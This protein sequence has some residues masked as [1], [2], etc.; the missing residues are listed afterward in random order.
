MRL[1]SFGA[2]SDK[3]YSLCVFFEEGLDFEVEKNLFDFLRSRSTPAL[4]F[5]YCDRGPLMT[6]EL[7]FEVRDSTLKR[8]IFTRS[9]PS[10][11]AKADRE[12]IERYLRSEGIEPQVSISP[13]TR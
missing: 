4:P 12:E 1:T 9:P 2:A 7:T 3:R 5:L 8:I 6:V 10:G 13:L 11:S